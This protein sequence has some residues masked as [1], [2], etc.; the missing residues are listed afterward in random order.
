MKVH[1]SN[2]RL[3]KRGEENDSWPPV[4]TKSYIT[5]A[6]MYQKDLQ[7]SEDTTRTIFLRTK[8]DISNIPKKVNSQQFTDISQLFSCKSGSI[9]NCILIDGHP[10]IGKTTFVKE[11][12]IEWAEGKLLTSDKLVLLLLLRDP[13]VQRITNTQQLIQHFTKSTS[14]V[15]QLHSYLED[16]HH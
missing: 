9:P 15:T 11:I 8:G 16:T 12:C 10:G 7:T 5:L 1:Y 13:N 3:K 6:L 2:M 4:K 14:K